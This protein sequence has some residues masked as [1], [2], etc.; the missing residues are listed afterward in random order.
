MIYRAYY[1]ALRRLLGDGNLDKRVTHIGF[2]SSA[3]SPNAEVSA[4]T[5]PVL[6]PIAAVVHHPTDTRRTA[7]HFLLPLDEGVGLTIREIGLLTADGTLVYREVR[8]PIT[9]T[10][11][12]EF[13]DVLNLQV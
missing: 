4:L 13:G 3:A 11:D 5:T 10:A 1:D 6:T 2:G 9:K 8:A 7:F 12:M